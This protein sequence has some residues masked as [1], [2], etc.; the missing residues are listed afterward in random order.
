MNDSLRCMNYR[1]LVMKY[2]KLLIEQLAHLDK[3]K[4]CYSHAGLL[5]K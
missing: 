1:L 5:K 4:S 3:K 2:N